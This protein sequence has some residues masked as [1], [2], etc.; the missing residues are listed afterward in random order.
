MSS[1]ADSPVSAEHG[2][3]IFSQGEQREE[4]STMADPL[5]TSTNDLAQTNS[6][7]ET[8]AD[9]ATSSGTAVDTVASSSPAPTA[10]TAVP[11]PTTV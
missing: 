4:L 6:T 11:G 5:P 2:A 9:A 8:T 7:V 1:A 10:D 3:E